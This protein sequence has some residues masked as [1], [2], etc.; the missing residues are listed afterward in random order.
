MN[1]SYK[2]RRES[3]LREIRFIFTIRLRNLGRLEM[4]TLVIGSKN[5][6]FRLKKTTWYT[7]NTPP[8]PPFYFLSVN[9]D[10][11]LRSASNFNLKFCFVFLVKNGRQCMTELESDVLIEVDDFSFLLHKVICITNFIFNYKNSSFIL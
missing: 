2:E 7:S 8:P 9:L 3:K 4:A 5:G 6:I 1:T 11:L 10:M